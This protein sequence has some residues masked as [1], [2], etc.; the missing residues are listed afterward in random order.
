MP[1]NKYF[2]E[3]DFSLNTATD[4]KVD[5]VLK[6]KQKDWIGTRLHCNGIVHRYRSQKEEAELKGHILLKAI[7]RGK[8]EPPGFNIHSLLP[9]DTRNDLLVCQI[10]K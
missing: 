9:F 4:Q 2:N 5:W 1:T 8:P 3:V 10:L 6:S 7:R